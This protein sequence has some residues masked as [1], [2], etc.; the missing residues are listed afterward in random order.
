[1]TRLH[2]AGMRR[3]TRVTFAANGA[4]ETTVAQLVGSGTVFPCRTSGQHLQYDQK[5]ERYQVDCL[6][7]LRQR[8][9]EN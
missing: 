7:V 5:L 6:T 9:I 1:M 8:K 4:A 2:R 3:V